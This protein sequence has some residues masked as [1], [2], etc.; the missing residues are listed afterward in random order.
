MT[1][2]I[3]LYDEF[4]KEERF[5][6]TYSPFCIIPYD[7]FRFHINHLNVWKLK[8]ITHWKYLEEPEVE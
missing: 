3:K 8:K 7:I 1:D 5:V 2:W 4:P 6:V